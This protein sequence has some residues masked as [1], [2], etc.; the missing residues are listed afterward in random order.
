MKT[1]ISSQE[2]S[3]LKQIGEGTEAIVYRAGKGML[4]KVYK[5]KYYI[6]IGSEQVKKC[7]S[8]RII[9]EAARRQQFIKHST[10]PLNPLYIDGK[11]KGCVLKEHRGYGDIYNINILPQKTKIKL[12]KQLVLNVKELIEH[13]IY[14][15][16]LS[17]KSIP[18]VH[19]GN[20]LVSL[21]GDLQ[22]IDLDGKSTTYT[23][24]FDAQFYQLTVQTLLALIT[25]LL[26]ELDMD[27]LYFEE[28][29]YITE[30]LKSNGFPM[31]LAETIALQRDSSF[32]EIDEVLEC[33]SKC[34]RIIFN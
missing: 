29:M 25:D 17:N 18:G 7:Y 12:L 27:D 33:A 11:F 30:K 32:E 13:N 6:A 34:K 19:K 4:Y 21:T 9:E 10:L 28:V 24:G 31:N 3:R 22:L 15:V 1:Y 20:V 23:N 2:L 26:F 5:N 14:H 8:P 16:D